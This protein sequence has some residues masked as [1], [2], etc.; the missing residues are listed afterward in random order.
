MANLKTA[1][2]RFHTN[3]VDKDMTH[4]SQLPS[5]RGTINLRKLK[6]LWAVFPTIAKTA[7]LV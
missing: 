5:K 1:V 4:N 7:P 3:D 6:G 2:A